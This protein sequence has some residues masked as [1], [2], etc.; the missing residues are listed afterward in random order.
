MSDISASSSDPDFVRE[1]ERFY[2]E[3]ELVSDD[4]V[5]TCPCGID[6][7]TP[8][9]NPVCARANSQGGK[10]IMTFSDY[11]RNVEKMAEQIKAKFLESEKYRLF[12]EAGLTDPTQKTL[13]GQLTYYEAISKI[14]DLK[15]KKD[16]EEEKNREKIAR[17]ESFA[18]MDLNPRLERDADGRIIVKKRN[19]G[20]FE[21]HY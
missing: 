5:F 8:C 6:V 20:R 3:W 15:G 16:Q 19:P 14:A 12:H 7:R 18:Q 2:S 17:Q 13:I 21:L 4:H 9:Q 10:L 11:M 1:A